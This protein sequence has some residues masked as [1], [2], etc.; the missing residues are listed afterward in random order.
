M[1]VATLHVVWETQLQWAICPSLAF[2][3][4]NIQPL[5]LLLPSRLQI[6]QIHLIQI[7]L[8]TMTN[9]R[10]LFFQLFMNLKQIYLNSIYLFTLL[11][12][13][14]IPVT[15]NMVTMKLGRYIVVSSIIIR[16]N[17]SCLHMPRKIVTGWGL[18][19]VKGLFTLLFYKI[20][21]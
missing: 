3:V 6:L 7:L 1:I 14:Y 9:R 11:F 19:N 2:Y 16:L 10:L 15:W 8:N 18:V 20:C 17:C 13:L 21:T 5:P 12:N 4:I